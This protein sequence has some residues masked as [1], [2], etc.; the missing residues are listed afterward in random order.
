MRTCT[1]LAVACVAV[2]VA[3]ARGEPAADRF[4]DP[5]PPGAIARIGTVRWRHAEAVFSVA[6]SPDGKHLACGSQDGKVLFWAS[7]GRQVRRLV[8]HSAWVYALAFSPDG[9]T[10]ATGGFDNTARLWDAA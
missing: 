5:L 1:P 9:K 3:V 7:D 6:F 4:G 8:G 10:V 2:A